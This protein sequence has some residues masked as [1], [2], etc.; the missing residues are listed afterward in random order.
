[1]QTQ[2]FIQELIGMKNDMSVEEMIAMKNQIS[3]AEVLVM[4]EMVRL[5]PYRTFRILP[6][7][8]IFYFC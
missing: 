2:H 8:D 1:M 7:L 4:K 6:I 5:L 3:V